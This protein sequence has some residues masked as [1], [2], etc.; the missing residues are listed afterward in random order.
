MR[1]IGIFFSQVKSEMSKVA[2]PSKEELISSTTVVL[3]S[4]IVVALFI[5]ICD[6]VL[7]RVINI[8]ISGVF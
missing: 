7:S 4:V 1:K 2:W 6:L 3:A 5:G 8:L